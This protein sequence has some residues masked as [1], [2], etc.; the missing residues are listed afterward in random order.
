MADRSQ[1]KT[2]ASFST[3]LDAIRQDPEGVFAS[4]ARALSDLSTEKLS[5]LKPVLAALDP[6]KKAAFFR[7]MDVCN[8]ENYIYDFSP[9]AMTGLDD[10]DGEVRKASINILGLED[11]REIGSRML[12]LALNDPYEDAQIAAIRVLG[13][14]MYEAD[15]EN[16]IPVS[17]KKLRETLASLLDSEK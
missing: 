9:I 13:E 3:V 8:S 15:I 17:K 14:Y 7:C 4:Y 6:R 12:E 5:Q 11:S 1:K 16:A 10:P 2:R